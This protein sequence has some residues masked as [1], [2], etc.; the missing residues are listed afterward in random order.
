MARSCFRLTWPLIPSR[1]ATHMPA[2]EQ[3]GA[4]L[5]A[6]EGLLTE[7]LHERLHS[8]LKMP[9]TAQPHTCLHRAFIVQVLNWHETW[10]AASPRSRSGSI[11]RAL[12]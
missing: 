8:A 11:A 4:R 12:V 9:Q 6:A 2:M 3:G 10:V 7:A 5:A 1:E